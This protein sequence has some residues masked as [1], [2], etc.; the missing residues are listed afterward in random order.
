MA[1]GGRRRLADAPFDPVVGHLGRSRVWLFAYVRIDCSKSRVCVT[2]LL[3][4]TRALLA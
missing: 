1:Q 4:H 2:I 3:P